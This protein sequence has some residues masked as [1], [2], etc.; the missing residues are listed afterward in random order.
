VTSDPR[1]WF[2]AKPYGWGWG[3]PISWQGWLVFVAF[4][5]LIIAGAFLFSALFPPRR[6]L[7]AFLTAYLVY[8]AILSVVF[9]A[10]AWAK[11]EPPRWRWGEDE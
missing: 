4:L 10:V 2:A 8:V 11:G 7:A 3:F 5:V 1:Y 9:I 6:A